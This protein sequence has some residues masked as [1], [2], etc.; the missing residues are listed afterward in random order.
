M[1]R[2]RIIKKW[3]AQFE[4]IERLGGE[5]NELIVEPPATEAEVARVERELG[6]TLPPVMRNT[7]LTFARG[8]CVGWQLPDGFSLPEPVQQALGGEIEY[9]G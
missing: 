3:T 2:D 8:I 7:F 1:D 9:S 6:V 5:T 4:V